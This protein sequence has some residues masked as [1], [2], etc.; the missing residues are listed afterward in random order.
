MRVWT[1]LGLDPNFGIA[2]KFSVDLRRSSRYWTKFWRISITNQVQWFL[3]VIFEFELLCCFDLFW[4]AML[5]E[6]CCCCLNY[7]IRCSIGFTF[8]SFGYI[9]VSKPSP[10]QLSI[11][12]YLTIC[13]VSWILLGISL[14]GLCLFELNPL[15]VSWLLHH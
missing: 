6:Q 4:A 14:N 2:L 13:F 5:F 7:I 8:G 3:L 11:S 9:L 1:N 12:V 15:V 10:E